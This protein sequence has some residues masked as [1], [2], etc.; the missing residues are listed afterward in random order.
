MILKQGEALALI[1]EI[2]DQSVD[3]VFADM[4]FEPQDGS[5]DM[6]IY[7]KKLAYQF[8]RVLKP[9]RN[10]IVTNNPYNMW[11]IKN[12]FDSFT[13]RDMCVLLRRSSFNCAWNVSFTHNYLYVFLKGTD[14]KERWNGPKEHHK[15][16]ELKDVIDYVPSVIRITTKLRC[17]TISADLIKLLIQYYSNPGDTVLDPFMRAGIAAQSCQILKRNFIGFEQHPEYFQYVKTQISK[18]NTL[19]LL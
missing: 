3:L 17:Q 4:P 18:N 9:N 16:G 19:G 6:S 5:K 2:P 7:A 11:K 1:Q 14:I 10:L 8:H 15:Q 12:A 13:I